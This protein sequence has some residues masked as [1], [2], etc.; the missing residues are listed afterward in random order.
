MRRKALHV[1]STLMLS[2]VTLSSCAS[3]DLNNL[4]PGQEEPEY[5]EANVNKHM[6]DKLES[7]GSQAQDDW[8]IENLIQ[9]GVDIDEQDA[10]Q[11]RDQV[12]S[13]I[14]SRRTAGE[15]GETLDRFTEEQAGV[16]IAS[17]MISRC[18]DR[19]VIM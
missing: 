11:V 1:A 10:F 6:S 16:I 14:Q 17:S 13:M 4:S 3:N 12:C 9:S 18:P 8:F 19:S 2:I 5:T 7:M 15:I